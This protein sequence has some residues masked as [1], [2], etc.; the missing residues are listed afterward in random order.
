MY[1]DVLF[2][3]I[4]FLYTICVCV[5]VRACVHMCVCVCVCVCVLI[6]IIELAS[7]SHL[8]SLVWISIN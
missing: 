2:C 4:N 7:Q 6:D 5:C 8:S 1:K 3:I